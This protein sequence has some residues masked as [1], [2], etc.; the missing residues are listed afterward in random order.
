MTSHER[1][2]VTVE[3]SARS[4]TV[5]LPVD[6]EVAE[7]LPGIVHASGH[8]SAV[9]GWS[10]RQR[11]GPLV[12]PERSLRQSGVLRGSV[13]RLVDPLDW[14]GQVPGPGAATVPGLL[15]RLSRRQRLRLAVA[16]TLSADPPRWDATAYLADQTP[17]QAS[18]P[19][20]VID[21]RL[22]T[23][24]PSPGPLARAL[25]AWRQS[26]HGWRLDQ[27]IVGARSQLGMLVV[28]AAAEA[29]A[30]STTITALAAAA[31]SALRRER[32]VIVDAGLG[33]S[34]LTQRLA[35]D[36][37]LSEVPF[38]R[39]GSRPATFAEFEAFLARGPESAALLPAPE[40]GVGSGPGDVRRWSGLLMQMLRWMPTVI[41]DC[42]LT[43]SAAEAALA[44]ADLVVLVAARERPALDDLA[45]TARA[46]RRADRDVVMVAN[47]L[48]A[49][50]VLW[51]PAL[52][53]AGCPLVSVPHDG[54]AA[55]L[56]RS[57]GPVWPR[58]PGS[59]RTAG[60]ELAALVM[61]RHA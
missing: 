23:A 17:P 6:V 15:P 24:E 7:L 9:D 36:H 50:L 61:A 3:S 32:I 51:P 43:G 29:G 41:V 38:D 25:R 18:G 16:A 35:P 56:A 20:A 58:L 34:P 46:L 10:L 52:C 57:A 2:L 5:E 8:D 22:L 60:S 42:G 13:L 30:G 47:H 39:L 37:R 11:E 1:L 27:V 45:R 4:V 53:P 54:P 48:R 59:W 28:V 14:P 49:G 19:G 40:P 21:P 55:G 26:Y 31:L 12:D 33:A 44:A